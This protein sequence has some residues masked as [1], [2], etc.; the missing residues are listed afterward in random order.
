MIFRKKECIKL[1]LEI[2]KNEEKSILRLLISLIFS[3]HEQV[4]RKRLCH[5]MKE[6]KRTKRSQSVLSCYRTQIKVME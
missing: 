5:G 2:S 4:R 6:K 3:R 1:L